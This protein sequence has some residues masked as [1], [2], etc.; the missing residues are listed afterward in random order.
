MKC[1]RELDDVEQ[2]VLCMHFGF[3]H[4]EFNDDERTY[5]LS[6]IQKALN[7]AGYEANAINEYRSARRHITDIM[8]KAGVVTKRNKY[9]SAK[10]EIGLKFKDVETVNKMFEA[11]NLIDIDD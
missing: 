9:Q 1:I 10:E 2:I 5:K 4:P 8:Y 7:A 11:L 6:E 3:H